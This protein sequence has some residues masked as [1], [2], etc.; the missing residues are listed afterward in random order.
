[1]ADHFH[2]HSFNHYQ[3]C[4]TILHATTK[5]LDYHHDR[6][7]FRMFCQTLVSLQ[8]LRDH[9]SM[10]SNF[11]QYYCFQNDT[12]ITFDSLDILIDLFTLQCL[13]SNS[14]EISDPKNIG[15]KL[16]IGVSPSIAIVF[17]FIAVIVCSWKYLSD[18]SR[19]SVPYD[20]WDPIV[21]TELWGI[22][23]HSVEFELS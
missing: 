6:Q 22:P 10:F 12:K 2:I 11:E 17:G 18:F 7:H 15:L 21:D 16:T 23:R 5:Q 13:P 4:E 1:M 19:E 20:E 14:S 8:C 9:K 3:N